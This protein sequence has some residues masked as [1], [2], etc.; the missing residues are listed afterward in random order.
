MSYIM[1]PDLTTFAVSVLVVIALA[2]PYL[3]VKY[4]VRHRRATG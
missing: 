1:F 2:T 3:L 4:V